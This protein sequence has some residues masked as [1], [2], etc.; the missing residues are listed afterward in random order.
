MI[1]LG[2]TYSEKFTFT[3][4]EVDDFIRIS[5]DNNPIHHS[6]QYSKNTIFK[7]PIIHGF[8]S[9]S[10]FSKILG[11]ILPGEGT[12]YMSQSL[13]F[14]APMYVEELYQGVV[15][16]VEVDATKGICILQTQVLDE[17]GNVMITGEAKVKNRQKTSSEVT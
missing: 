10:V 2:D 14:T 8:L 16:V 9:A 5:G 6:K 11:T 4:L 7:K 13:K 1:K 12:I 17:A 15:E 3:Q